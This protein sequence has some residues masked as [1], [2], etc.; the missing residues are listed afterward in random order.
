MNIYKQIFYIN[1][2]IDV[3]L[4]H[5]KNMARLTKN[6]STLDAYAFKILRKYKFH[7]FCWSQ[8]IHEILARISA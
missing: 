7:E 4:Y 1:H 6:I 2:N 5:S 3:F 8:C